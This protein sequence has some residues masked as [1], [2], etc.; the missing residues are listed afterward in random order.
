MVLKF[1]KY[2][3]YIK[4]KYGVDLS[5]VKINV[6]YLRIGFPGTYWYEKGE[7]TVNNG[8]LILLPIMIFIVAFA[9]PKITV[10]MLI[11]EL[12]ISSFCI[13]AILSTNSAIMH[14]LMHGVIYEIAKEKT[15]NIADYLKEAIC[16]Y[17]AINAEV[18]PKYSKYAS[19][20]LLIVFLPLYIVRNE[21]LRLSYQY[22]FEQIESLGN[23]IK[24]DLDKL[25]E[26]EKILPIAYKD[27]II[28]CNLVKEE[29]LQL[30]KD[31]SLQRTL[32]PE[33]IDKLKKIKVS[34][35]RAFLYYLR[36]LT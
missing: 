11:S 3:K 8:I 20:L 26:K 1:D 24:I 34:F 27:K 10:F 22:L 21:R 23:E 2:K 29:A 14:E 4:S 35:L 19:I 15:F 28:A 33:K 13:L 32:I 7:I 31:K 9:I 6:S 25:K 12:I 18:V 5:H 30:I 36:K 16:E 17:E